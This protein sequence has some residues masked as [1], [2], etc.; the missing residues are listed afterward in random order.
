MAIQKLLLDDFLDE[1]DYVLIGIH[2]AIEDYRLAYFINKQLNISLTRKRLDIDFS[3]GTHFSIFEWIDEKKMATWNL[4]TNI[5]KVEGI[6]KKQSDTLFQT[7][8]AITTTHHLIPELKKVNYFLKISDDETSKTKLKLLLN[9][10]QSIPQI[11]TAYTI[12]PSE[13]KSKHNLIFY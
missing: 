7:Q 12:I 9:K 1:A 2:C 11:V 4:V 13:L 6:D 3:N 8:D 10:I 5:C